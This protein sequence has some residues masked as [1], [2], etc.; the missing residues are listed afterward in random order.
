MFLTHIFT[1]QNFMRYLSGK[2][3]DPDRSPLNPQ[4]NNAT[5]HIGRKSLQM[6]T[7]QLYL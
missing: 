1:T 4:V 2:S 7:L 3:H 5:G 6:I